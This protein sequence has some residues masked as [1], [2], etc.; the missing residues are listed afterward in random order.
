MR[1]LGRPA[2]ALPGGSSAEPHQRGVEVARSRAR[3]AAFASAMEQRRVEADADREDTVSASAGE[4]HQHQR[5]RSAPSGGCVDDRR[6]DQDADQR[7]RGEQA[8]QPVDQSGPDRAGRRRTTSSS[9][10]RRR[11]FM[12]VGHPAAVAM[13]A[14][15]GR[16]EHDAR[17]RAAHLLDRLA[18]RC[19]RG[20][21]TSSQV[22]TAAALRE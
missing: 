21:L 3:P 13:A 8:R 19:R 12:A 10:R 15:S 17:P 4:R 9:R 20:A 1:A 14:R 7:R 2:A 16:V 18:H 6:T 11:S 5:S 22:A